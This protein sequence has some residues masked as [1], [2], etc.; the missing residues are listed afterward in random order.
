MNI[1]ELKKEIE[2]C[3]DIAFIDHHSDN[4]VITF[5]PASAFFLYKHDLSAKKLCVSSRIPNYYLYNPGS[6]CKKFAKFLLAQKVKNIIV[7]G[8]SKAG[9]AGL[10]WGKLLDDILKPK[11]INVFILTFSP[12]TQLYPFNENLGFP[13]YQKFYQSFKNDNGLEKCAKLYGNL[14]EIFQDSD[15]EGLLIYPEHNI[16][17]KTEA[18][19]LA[20]SNIKLVSIDSPLHGTIFPFMLNTDNEKEVWNMVD[21]LYSKIEQDIDL[22]NTLPESPQSLFNIISAIKTPSL[23]RLCSSIFTLLERKSEIK[24]LKHYDLV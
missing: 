19:K 10:L 21:K 22:K 3:Y 12:Q 23:E 14:V 13:S 15:V 24:I 16:C 17:D 4:L 20:G 6:M 1:D 9:F 8:S 5:T 2:D 18:L 7:I 11:D